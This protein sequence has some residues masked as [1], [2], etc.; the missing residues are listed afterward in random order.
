MIF[1]EYVDLNFLILILMS[2]SVL[3][4]MENM[5]YLRSL[6]SNF[7]SWHAWRDFS[8]LLVLFPLAIQSCYVS[9]FYKYNFLRVN[10]LNESHALSIREEVYSIR[11]PL[12]I[13]FKFFGILNVKI[14]YYL[15]WR[16]NVR[17]ITIVLDGG[18]RSC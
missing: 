13:K 1:S 4:T 15:K 16:Q 2:S 10:K 3:P 12:E 6:I 9:Q 7:N 17:L 5:Q 18:L 8:L 14:C 11:K